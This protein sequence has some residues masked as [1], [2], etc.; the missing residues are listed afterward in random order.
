MTEKNTSPL[1]KEKLLQPVR[2][3]LSSLYSNTLQGKPIHSLISSSTSPQNIQLDAITRAG[4]IESDGVIITID[5]TAIQDISS[6]TFKA[7]IIF[8][9]KATAQL[10]RGNAITAEAIQRGRI[11][12]ISL[13]EYMEDCGVKDIKN[14]REQ[15]N[16]AIR[17]LYY[18]SLEWDETGYEKPEGKSR[19]VKVTK[20]HRM[21]I[22]DHTITPSEK[23]PVKRGVAEVRLSFDM[24]EY[25]SNSYIMPYHRNLLRINTKLH[26][27][28]IPLGWKLCAL[29]NMNYGKEKRA[30]ET[31]VQTLLRAAKGIPRYET[32]ADTGQIYNRIIKPF[33]R[34]LY[35][36]VEAEVLSCYWYYDDMGI[37]IDRKQIGGLSYT[38]FSQLNLHYELSGYPDQTPRLEERSKKISAAIGRAKARKK[39]KE[40]EESGEE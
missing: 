37:R 14:A 31:T 33:D 39:K 35:A 21:R 32:I 16:D 22:T 30:N 3:D 40:Q 2:E 9:T 26:P 17:A 23:N 1:E 11:V 7:L 4:T 25:L 27:Y 34:D 29:H 5:E 24:A 8:L 20:H 13:Q 19:A 18:V 28:S 10:P 15:L 36:L 6:Q 38:D 12:R